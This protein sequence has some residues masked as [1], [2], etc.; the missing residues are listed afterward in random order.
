MAKEKKQYP[1]VVLQGL[2][3]IMKTKSDYHI[4]VKSDFVRFVDID[5]TSDFFF[6]ITAFEFDAQKKVLFTIQSKPRNPNSIDA[7]ER[8]VAAAHVID[9]LKTWIDLLEQYSKVELFDDPILKQYEEEFTADFELLDEDADDKSYGLQVQVLIDNYLLE[10]KSKLLERKTD[11]NA[12]AVSKIEKEIDELRENQTT[13]PKRKVVGKL[14]K[15]L[16]GIR[17]VS[18]KL[19]TDTFTVARNEIVKALIKG[20]IDNMNLPGS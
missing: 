4:L 19:L 1:L 14:A 12:D 5:P 3:A 10:W 7:Y 20:Q 8:K 18:L 11:L 16:A 15:I 6:E 17:K 13:L 2:E 9:H